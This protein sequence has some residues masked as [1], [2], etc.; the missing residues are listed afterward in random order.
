MRRTQPAISGFEGGR[1]LWTK[2]CRQPL[3]VENSKK[4]DSPLGPPEETQQCDMLILAQWISFQI[5]DL[6]NSKVINLCW[7]KLLSFSNLL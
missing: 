7:F 4:T 5:S 2:Q 3:E 1:E 6:Q